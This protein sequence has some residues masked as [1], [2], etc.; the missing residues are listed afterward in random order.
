MRWNDVVSRFVQIWAGRSVQGA[1]PLESFHIIRKMCE[2][3]LQYCSRLQFTKQF[4]VARKGL[5]IRIHCF[6]ENTNCSHTSFVWCCPCLTRTPFCID[7]C[8]IRSKRYSFMPLNL[9]DMLLLNRKDIVNSCCWNMVFTLAGYIWIFLTTHITG[10]LDT[11]SHYKISQ[12]ING[13]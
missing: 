11:C 6:H 3:V 9:F 2:H 4:S 13:E 7:R 12:K 5:V 8:Y 1:I 10:R